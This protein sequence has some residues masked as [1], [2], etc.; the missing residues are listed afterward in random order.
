MAY[1]AYNE[2]HGKPTS[3]AFSWTPIKLGPDIRCKLAQQTAQLASV[4]SR[5]NSVSATEHVN[6]R[7][8]SNYNTR[9]K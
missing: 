1:D 5:H 9:Q 4:S 3:Q 8:S 6:I 7:L 2:E